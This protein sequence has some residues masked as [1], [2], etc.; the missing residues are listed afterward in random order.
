MGKPKITEDNFQ[1]TIIEMAQW[2][3]WKVAHFRTARKADGTW[4]TP[5]EAD[6]EGFPDLVLVHEAQRRLIF[7]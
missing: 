2:L 5:V 3:G 4:Y 6:G 1:Q 7:V